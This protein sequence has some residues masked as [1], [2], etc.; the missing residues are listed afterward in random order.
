MINELV[1]LAN[2]NIYQI[3]N[4]KSEYVLVDNIQLA[5]DILLSYDNDF[6]QHQV[7]P[8]KELESFFDKEEQVILHTWNEYLL[9]MGKP[10]VDEK[11]RERIKKLGEKHDI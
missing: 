10:L 4:F 3:A 8:K 2:N 6:Y 7:I 1:N 5:I 11:E 9:V